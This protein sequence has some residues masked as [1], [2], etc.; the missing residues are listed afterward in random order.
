MS[1]VA[2]NHFAPPAQRAQA[3]AALAITPPP[4]AW[5]PL[6]ED[7]IV[8]D[9]RRPQAMAGIAALPIGEIVAYGAALHGGYAPHEV[10]ALIGLDNIRLRVARETPEQSLAALIDSPEQ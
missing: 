9:Q 3:Q 7:F 8:L 6:F 5:A 1:A 10:D 2:A 4:F